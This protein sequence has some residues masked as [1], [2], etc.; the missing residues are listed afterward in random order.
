MQR[1]LSLFPF[2]LSLAMARSVGL[3]GT[4]RERAKRERG[5][6][7]SPPFSSPLSTIHHDPVCVQPP[8]SSREKPELKGFVL[9]CLLALPS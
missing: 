7:S 6:L 2:L 5:A 8:R 4:Q 1:G 3:V 9:A